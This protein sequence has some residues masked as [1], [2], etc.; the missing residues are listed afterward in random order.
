MIDLLLMLLTNFDRRF[1]QK[2]VSFLKSIVA[3]PGSYEFGSGSRL[4]SKTGSRSRIPFQVFRFLG[5]ENFFLSTLMDLDLDPEP[6]LR[7]LLF[8]SMTFE[9]P[10]KNKFFNKFFLLITYCRYI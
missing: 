9:M 6:A 4:F 10:A 1:D 5:L 8:S 2:G 3:D 7:I